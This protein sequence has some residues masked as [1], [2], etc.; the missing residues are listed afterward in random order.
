MIPR[1]SA[2][3][4]V[5]AL[6]G[7]AAASATTMQGGAEG[8]SN[9]T[10]ARA[11]TA[12]SIKY[13]EAS[14]V[15]GSTGT[16]ATM[17]ASAGRKLV[18]VEVVLKGA[19][20]AAFAVTD[21]KLADAKGATYQAVGVAGTL[22]SNFQPFSPNVSGWVG[23]FGPKGPT[24]PIVRIGRD[25]PEEPNRVEFQGEGGNLFLVYTV[26]AGAMQLTIAFGEQHPM[27]VKLEP[28]SGR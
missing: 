12:D 15:P 6:L 8:L 23:T 1:F 20:R 25:K 7:A 9:L 2:L 5:C 22:M 28:A 27:P 13:S 10:V 16:D 21:A 3:A 24:G 18:V 17:R 4:I 26:P 14:P 19:A 11:W